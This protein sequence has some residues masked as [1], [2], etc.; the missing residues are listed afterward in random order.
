MTSSRRY[1]FCPATSANPSPVLPAVASTIVLP[2][3][4]LP[5]RSAA[6]IIESP[7]RSLIEP[8]GFWF[9]SF[10]NSRQGPASSFVASIIGVLPIIARTERTGAAGDAMAEGAGAGAV[11]M[12]TR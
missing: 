10:R 3:L 12:P 1:P 2:G 6:S 7:I 9:S 5:S 8:A 4:I 11:V